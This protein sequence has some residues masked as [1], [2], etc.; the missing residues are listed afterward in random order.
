MKKIA[1]LFLSFI[2]LAISGFYLADFL[3]PQL[4]VFPSSVPPPHREKPTKTDF[5]F[6]Y[7]LPGP[8][9]IR[10][11]L[12]KEAKTFLEV[13]LENMT[14]RFYKEGI[15]EKEVPILRKGDPQGWGGTAAGLYQ[16]DLKSKLT[17]SAIAE[18]YMPYS[19]RLYGKYYLHGEPYYSS[20]EKLVSDFSGG[21]V[22]LSNENAKFIY[23]L[24]ER[25]TPVLV[26]DK[27]NETFF[28]SAQKDTSLP[29]LSA[30]SYLAADLDSGFV[31][32]EKNP[33]EI[34]PITS[35][36]KLMTATIVSEQVDLRKSISISNFML[37]AC[38]KTKGLESGQKYRVVELFYPLL[39]QSSNDAAEV[40]SYFLGR[41]RTINLMNEKAKSIMMGKTS[42]SDPSGFDPGNVSTTK[43][44]FILARYLVNNRPLIFEITRGQKVRAFGEVRFKDL[45]NKNFFY[46]EENFIGGKT[47]YITA[48]KHNG[49]FIFR[50]KRAGNER[51]VAIIILG[52]EALQEGEK[53]LEAET[54]TLLSWLKENYF[55]ES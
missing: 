20:G 14:V 26:I 46:N 55:P 1:L 8:E 42:F 24:T 31:F 22:Q 4:V 12:L 28:Y 37:N 18:V 10:E 5:S 3:I 30:K 49:I 47:G 23:D 48:S 45:K 51:R 43:D 33:D 25:K 52:E 32:A 53:N 44:L 54:K 35:L 38:G 17:Y 21:C 50:L 41:K 27:E 6:H 36:T 19:L 29:D 16:I 40:L 2:A 9:K 39:I 15:L 13:N 11:D 7:F 34:L